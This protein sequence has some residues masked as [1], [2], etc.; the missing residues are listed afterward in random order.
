MADLT[1]RLVK[2]SPLTNAEVDGNFTSLNESIM[3]TGEPMGHVNRS[4]SVLSFNA[5]TR[6]V[7]ITPAVTSFDVW[8]KGTKYTYTTAQ[9][10]VIPDTTGLHYVFFTDAGVLSTR[11]SYFDFENE[12][13]TSYVAWNSVTQ[14]ASFFADERHGVTLDWQTHEYLHRTRG[15]A[16]ANG[17]S[18]SNY[19][20]VG[21]GSSDADAQF[22]L[23]GGT[24]FDEDLQVDIVSSNSPTPG[25]W[26]QDLAGPAL[27][28]VLYR[29]GTGWVRDTPT[30]FVLK[31]GTATPRYNTEAAGVWGLTDVP[32]NQY[33]TVWV[34][35]TN[36]LT[37]PVVAIMGQAA[38]SNSGQVE[39]IEWSSLN[40]DGFPS[41]EFRPLYKIVFQCSSSYTNTIKARFT[42][43]FDIRNLVAASPAATIGSAHSG[44]SGLGNDDHLQ[45]LHVTEVRSPSAAVKASFLPP[46]ASNAGKYL[47]TDGSVTSWEALTNPNNGTLTMSTSGT[48]IS[49]SATFTADQAGSSTFTVSLNSSATNVVNTVVLRDGSGNFSANVITANSF[50]G[51][52]SG[53]ASSATALAIARTISSTGDV[54]WSTSFDGSANATGT[55]TLSSTGVTAT[56][57]GSATQVATFTVDAK[58]R[59]T[60]ASSVNITPA[61]SSITGT[62]TSLAG[63]GITNGQPLDADLTAI[64]ALTGTSGFLKKT[65]TDTWTLDTSSYATTTGGGASGTWGISISGNAAT[66]T[67]AT[68]ASNVNNGTL[69]MNVSGVGLSGSQTFTANQSG[70]ATFTV[71]SNAT[72]ANTGSTIV[73]RDASGNFSAG[74]ITASLSGNASTATTAT[75]AGSATTA[76]TASTANALNTAN[77]YTVNGL[78]VSTGS[79]YVVANRTS[80]SSGQVGYNWAQGGTNLW[81]SYVDTNNTRLNWYNSVT[82]T[83]VMTLTTGG[84]L[85]VIGAI[86]QNNN[87]VLHA[88]NYTSYSP[89]L[90]GSGASGTW[91]INVTGSAGSA[92]T[93][94]NATQLG[95]YA[96]STYVGKFGNTYYQ[97]DTWIQC[98]GIG[99]LY[100]PATN[101]AELNAN[102]NSSYGAVAVVGARN[103]WRGIHIQGGGNQPHLMF[104]GSSN[105]GVYFES[106]G[107]WASYYN[108]SNNCWNFGDSTTSSTYNLYASKGYYAGTRIDSPI[109]YDANNTGYYVD[110]S[111]TSNIVNL[112]TTDAV[113][114]N[115]NGLRNINPGGGSYVTSASTVSGA[116]RIALPQTSY[117]MI[118][119]T[120]RVYTYD[121]LSFDI[122]CGGH[123][124]GSTWYN[125][126]AYMGTQNRPALN[127]RFTSD[128]STMYVYIGELG[129]SWSY[130]QVFITD[131][132]AGYTN[133][134]YD[135][136]DNGWAVTFN[137]SSYNTIYSTHTVY[138]PTSST[139]NSNA[140][141]AS[142]F[143]DSNNTAYYTD[144][145]STSNLVGLTVANTI[146]GSISGNAATITSQ[147][148]S[149][150]I[151]ATTTA[152]ANRIVLRDGN[153]D[154]YRRYGFSEYF[155]MSH[156]ASGST[157]DTTFYSSTDNYIRKN[158][159]TG[160]RA[161][162][163]VPTRTGGD[164]SGT[165]SINVTGSSG[166]TTNATNSTNVSITND[167]STNATYYPAFMTGTSG[168]GAVRVSSTKLTFNPS[169]GAL[170]ATTV[171]G[172]SDERIK[173]NW[174]DLPEDLIE[175]LA[176]VKAGVYDRTDMDVPVTQV[177]VTAQALRP[178]LP[179]AVIEDADGMLSVAYGNAALVAAVKLAQR[180]V[181]QDA[182]IARLE[183]L[184]DKLIGDQ[185]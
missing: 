64:A 117:P 6:T 144:P 179:N 142:I 111:S 35:A 159:A 178:V 45:Y 72:S 164:A 78:T 17:F 115:I 174:R 65:A 24:F 110:P 19:T 67:T 143:Y 43:V 34:I 36:N 123:T 41:V 28:P 120:V 105:G 118:R 104:D 60:A 160:F 83:D 76:T 172:N 3:V 23:G 165:W 40:L 136:W 167:T 87:Q 106:G 55:A 2:G 46:Q 54:A 91:S 51:P 96:A 135:R 177:G 1:L 175:Q 47:K 173:T 37:Y 30:N 169:T 150:T 97:A 119:F 156:S 149:A 52:L 13:P 66:A 61:W 89:S 113:S 148:N 155:N 126:F 170:I 171:A 15:A 116:I 180:V 92:A 26:Q 32:N 129:S 82:S 166:S 124:S 108:Y 122:Y 162:L 59:I 14:Q 81:W 73:A 95:G 50:S 75:S 11:M 161:S 146:T 79:A 145:A 181:E 125:T 112:R 9:T 127:V 93:A 56:S 4:D 163:N 27:I 139:N 63:Y 131:V 109:F 132:Q 74:T 86:T 90:T 158:N 71:T 147:A 183:S 140:A 151:T 68:T 133:Y 153:G 185:K 77:N 88:G 99:G 5:G 39:N 100:W 42:K 70:G 69:T 49:G 53:T 182:R 107:R 29:S 33:S 157:T 101:S 84:A 85:N 62:P 103:G 58:G 121:G 18:I 152:T 128:G 154:D 168:N 10:V 80:S 7:S 22:D 38:D 57:Y 130:P 31:A 25:T 114:N 94:T 184:L 8:C 137:S 141:Y 134:E 102:T 48:G 21:T 44:L 98:N 16:L 176:T 12:A 20:I 138:P